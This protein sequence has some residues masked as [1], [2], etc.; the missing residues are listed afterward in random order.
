[1]EQL[2][3]EQKQQIKVIK[4]KTREST[5]SKAKASQYLKE[6]G[7]LDFVKKATAAAE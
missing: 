3:E 7:S 4:D 5:K 6:S 1:M 2:S